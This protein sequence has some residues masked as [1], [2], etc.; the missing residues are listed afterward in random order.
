MKKFKKYLIEMERNS[1]YLG[2]KKGIQMETLP[3]NVRNVL[4]IPIIRIFRVIGGLSVLMFLLI[5]YDVISIELS[6]TVYI[7]LSFMAL[8]QLI[9]IVIISIIKF[10]YGL[11]KL[12]KHRKDFEVRNSPLNRLATVTANLVYC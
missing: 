11:N 3:K 2:L 4:D 5:R 7:L 12:I 9:Q 6:F 1:I 10:V 8:L